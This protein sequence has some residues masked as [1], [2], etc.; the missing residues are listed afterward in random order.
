MMCA[1]WWKVI[2]LLNCKYYFHHKQS[3]TIP[4]CFI[5]VPHYKWYDIPRKGKRHQLWPYILLLFQIA[6]GM[7]F[8]E[9]EKYIHRDL[10]ARNILVGDNYDVKVADFG[11]ARIIEDDEYCARQGGVLMIYICISTRYLINH[12]RLSDSLVECL[13][14]MD[15]T[16]LAVLSVNSNNCKQVHSV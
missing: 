6:S 16:I 15:L 12:A 5:A 3:V 7:A 11:L 4:F 2:S 1:L 9:K 13:P 10:A 8:L 14:K